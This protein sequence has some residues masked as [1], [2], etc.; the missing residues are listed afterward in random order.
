LSIELYIHLGA[1]VVSKGAL[2]RDLSLELRRLFILDSTPSWES[3]LDADGL[4][5]DA[6]SDF[7]LRVGADAQVEV[8]T[9]SVGFEEALGEEGGFW[10]SITASRTRESILLMIVVAGC[11]GRLAATNVVDDWEMLGRGPLLSPDVAL[12]VAACGS[13]LT[14]AEAAVALEVDL[15]RRKGRPLFGVCD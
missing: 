7:Q 11:L 8:G 5:G 10:T 14:F 2:L 15:S 4:L 3:E 9:L 1:T 6:D 12:G 13:G